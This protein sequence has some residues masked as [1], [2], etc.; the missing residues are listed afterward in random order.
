VA[1]LITSADVA[2]N[3]FNLACITLL[4]GALYGLCMGLPGGPRQAVASACKTPLVF[5]CT[6]AI[7][8]PVLYVAGALINLHVSVAQA[9]CLVLSSLALNALL[10]ACFAPLAAFFGLSS[11]YDFM[12]LLHV[13]V[14]T[15][16]GCY[17]MGV[18]YSAL[19]LVVDNQG[20]VGTRGGLLFV[21]WI[22]TYGFVGLQMAWT[23]RPLIGEPHLPFQWLRK[24][25]RNVSVYRAISLSIKRMSQ[26]K[27][28]REREA[29]L[30]YASR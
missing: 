11:D 8:F 23:L 6:M 29:A 26:S 7:C 12:K 5:L 19:R 13:G 25:T 16:C 14:F 1:A 18:L 2:S 22:V 20:E 27:E 3:C 4:L 21:L 17:S 28:P 9:A 10:L 15:V 24:R 30:E